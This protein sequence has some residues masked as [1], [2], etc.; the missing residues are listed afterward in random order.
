M[1][2]TDPRQTASTNHPPHYNRSSPNSRPPPPPRHQNHRHNNNNNHYHHHRNMKNNNNNPNNSFHQYGPA[3]RDPRNHHNHRNNADPRA[4]GRQ[5]Q[6]RLLPHHNHNNHH[7]HHRPQPHHHQP[8]HH[9]HQQHQ[10]QQHH[11][12]RLTPPPPPPPG[13]NN[14]NNNNNNH[15]NNHHNNHHNNRHAIHH[16]TPPPPPPPPRGMAH[17]TSSSFYPPPMLPPPPPPHRLPQ[18]QHQPVVLPPPPPTTATNQGVT[19]P[20]VP[21]AVV[22][23]DPATNPSNWS[24]HKAPTGVN[25]YYNSVTK[26][27][28]YTTPSCLEDTTKQQQAKTDQQKTPQN[29][30][31]DV[32]SL[33]QDWKEYTDAK[34][35]KKYYHNVKTNATSWDKPSTLTTATSSASPSTDK[36]KNTASTTSKSST[37]KKQK[38]ADDDRRVHKKAKKT[39]NQN[40]IKSKYS[41]KVEAIAAFKGMLLAKDITPYM[42]W[43]EV[44]KICSNDDRW[45]ACSTMGERKQALAEYQTKRANDI[46]D[47]KR[48]EKVRAKDAFTSLLSSV[49]T[50]D[51]MIGNDY[52]TIRPLLHKDDRFHAVEDDISREEYY[53]EFME[54]LRKRDD[55]QKRSRHRDAK[56]QF[57]QLLQTKK[58]SGT[59]THATTWST[60]LNHLKKKSSNNNNNNNT[61]VW[62][63]GPYLSDSDRQLY[64]ADY[65]LE[66]QMEEDDKRKRIRDAR[67]RAEK[68]QRDE[69]RQMLRQLVLK[70]D[71][72][73]PYYTRWR[74]VEE[75]IVAQ[76]NDVYQ[77]ILTQDRD[78]PRDL[79]EDFMEDWNES[80][81][82]D[83]SFLQS[84]VLRSSSIEESKMTA[85]T[86]YDDFV[87]LL[88]K[89]AAYSPDVYT[90]TR[91]IIKNTSPE[92]PLSSAKL[93]YQECINRAKDA[94]DMALKSMRASNAFAKRKTTPNGA[95]VATNEQDESSEDEGEILED[96][97]VGDDA[98]DDQ[99]TSNETNHHDETNKSQADDKNKESGDD[100][101]SSHV[102]N[103]PSTE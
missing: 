30:T 54:E 8:H 77:T 48:Q 6:Q 7:P 53:Y 33:Q 79:F 86:S 25:Y 49:I 35:G 20:I 94:A 19:V 43:N 65:L 82:R 98:L 59:L 68:A 4:A 89:E 60:F 52:S 26:V 58:E 23:E 51:C 92:L 69:Y 50:S 84:H 56:E 18:Q 12:N 27:S 11:H 13:H 10:H 45:G 64:F 31:T 15:N 74:N 83:R 96:E 67:R 37:S 2:P 87:S 46:R 81:R 90:D 17:P 63:V 21:V 5:P 55:R 78:A 34:S 29:N 41:S 102:C 28:T 80:Y 73:D 76:Y 40:N 36:S 75:I 9:H 32:Q 16:H 91:R 93:Y 99:G 1:N 47:T 42:K 66:L 24:T 14:N 70:L 57:L 88:L 39:L 85:K 71:N 100:D 22:K 101:S 95:A 72:C 61:S 44:V 3:S 103:K 38:C 97:I 62:E